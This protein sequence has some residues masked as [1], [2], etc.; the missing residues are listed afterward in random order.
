MFSTLTPSR[1][2]DAAANGQLRAPLQVSDTVQV[3]S[4]RRH[5]HHC[6]NTIRSTL[7]FL[8][9]R[10]AKAPCPHARDYRP[11][12]SKEARALRLGFSSLLA[13]S[14]DVITKGGRKLKSLPLLLASLS[15]Q[16]SIDLSLLAQLNYHHDPSCRRRTSSANQETAGDDESQTTR[17]EV[18][19]LG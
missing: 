15:L 1:F 11:S 17:I 6:I 12:S 10:S 9:L 4:W 16:Y 5:S 19:V 3:P 7:T 13:R 2:E 14:F 18:T 8:Q